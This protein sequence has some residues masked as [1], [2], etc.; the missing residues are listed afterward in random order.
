M[1]LKTWTYACLL[2][3]GCL[4]GCNE[5]LLPL[6]EETGQTSGTDNEG[7]NGQNE[8]TESKV[9]L[10]GKNPANPNQGSLAYLTPEG[11]L[12]ED[13]WQKTNGTTLVSNVRDLFICQGKLYILCSTDGDGKN[14]DGGLIV[15]DAATF[16]KEKTFA[17]SGIAFEKP[18]GTG[19]EYRPYLKTPANLAVIDERNVFI[20]DAQGLFRFDTTTGILTAIK[21]TYHIA[22]TIGGDG[23]LESKVSSRGL[24]ISNGKL[25]IG[26]AGFWS[27]QSGV[28]EIVP[29]K[30]EV[31]RTLEF[32]VDLVSGLTKGKDNELILTHY[33]RGTKRSN[34]VSRIS[35]ENFQTAETV[36]K[37]T[38]I[39]LAPGFFDKS[40]VA[41]DGNQ[42]LYLSE[43]EETETRVNYLMT[44]NRINLSD[45]T[46]ETLVD[47]KTEVPDAKYLTTTPVMDTDKQYV[48]VSVADNMY[49]GQTSNT[50]L[51]VYDCSGKEPVLKQKFS[52][53]TSRTVGIYF[54]HT[55]Q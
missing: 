48:Y 50:H 20:K 21:G 39:S 11:T 9:L 15:A 38:K 46:S 54:I 10:L 55:N 36:A 37:P 32:P 28:M 18:E 7:S 1:K 45:G 44:L 14:T 16:K 52:G 2:A 12:E 42:Y 41:Y 30:N 53:K 4:T 24:V 33:V 29:D 31:N 13:I 8:E 5:Q 27:D 34:E 51:L 3:L 23:N 49:E 43:I 22:N 25:Y 19:P 40:G 17:L 26:S 47:F 35:L 6:E